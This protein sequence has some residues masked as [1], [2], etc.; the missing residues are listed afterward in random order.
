MLHTD[1]LIKKGKQLI[2]Q[3]TVVSKSMPL[4][5][6]SNMTDEERQVIEAWYHSK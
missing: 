2:Y 4:G 6:L 5:N 1:E 3:N